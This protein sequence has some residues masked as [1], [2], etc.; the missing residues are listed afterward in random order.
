[1]TAT[2]GTNATLETRGNDQPGIAVISP[3]GDLDPILVRGKTLGA[4]Y[5]QSCDR[6]RSSLAEATPAEQAEFEETARKAEMLGTIY[7]EAQ[8]RYR[9]FLDA[10]SR[11]DRAEAEA[12]KAEHDRLVSAYMNAMA[13]PAVGMA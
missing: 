9:Q 13:A 3:A 12:A 7:E 11:G 6:F 10:A 1:M 8:D 2:L 4:T 5:R